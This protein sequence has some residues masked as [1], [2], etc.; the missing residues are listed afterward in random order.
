MKKLLLILVCI[1]FAGCKPNV[2]STNSGKGYDILMI[3]NCQYIKIHRASQ[4]YM[5]HKGNCTNSIHIY[6]KK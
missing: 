3:D 6:N 1:V 4:G 2:P 5:A